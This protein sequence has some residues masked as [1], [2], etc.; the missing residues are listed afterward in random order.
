VPAGDP[1]A[2]YA[3]RLRDPVLSSALR[4][5]LNG[6]IDLVL[7]VPGAAPGARPRYAIVDYKTN[8]LAP[9]GEPLTV[10]HY[11][12]GQLA[13]EMQRSHYALQALLYSVALHRYL[14]WRLD[15]YDPASDLAGVHYLVLRGMIGSAGSGVFSWQPAATL[16][17]ALSDLLAG[18]QER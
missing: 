9:A 11:G 18:G 17:S 10:A 8:W 14:R 13:A 7:R 16:V 15:A 1:L 4:G 3:A 12:P 2:G 6:S 5:Y